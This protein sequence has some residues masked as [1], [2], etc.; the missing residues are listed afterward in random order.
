MITCV[1]TTPGIRPSVIT[2]GACVDLLRQRCLS[3]G[4]AWRSV[5]QPS[6]ARST[7]QAD[8]HTLRT[9]AAAGATRAPGPRIAEHLRREGWRISDN[10][11]A[12]I[13]REHGLAARVRPRAQVHHPAGREPLACRRPG[14]ARLP[15]RCAGPAVGGR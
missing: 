13:M 10:T 8:G 7:R 14:Q 11:V 6:A 3:S 4:G 2:G 15:R 12:K 5:A 9:S 1:A